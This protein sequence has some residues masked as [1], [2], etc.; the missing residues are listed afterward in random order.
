M[1][2]DERYEGIPLEHYDDGNFMR[3]LGYGLL[4]SVPI[5]AML[6]FIV[7]KLLA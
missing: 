5:W 1:K 4:F 2:K 6:V 3:G 7:L